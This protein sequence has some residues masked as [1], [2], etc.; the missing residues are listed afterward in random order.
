[1]KLDGMRLLI[2]R[3]NKKI[4]LYTRHKNEVTFQFKQFTNLDIPEGTIIDGELVALNEMGVPDFELLME[5]Y[6]SKNSEGV[7]FVAFDVIRYQ[8]E[9]TTSLPLLER[10]RILN[11]II[12]ED[13]TLIAKTQFI[14]GHAKEYFQAIKDR[15][16]EGICLKRTDANR[17]SF[18]QVGK[19]SDTWLKLINYSYETVQI[20]G[21]RDGEFGA[22][23]S[24][25]DGRAAGVMEFAPKKDR[26]KIYDWA[27]KTGNTDKQNNIWFNEAMKCEVKYRNLT[28]KGLLRIPS[29]DKWV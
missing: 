13:N 29:F 9:D 27:R 20:T 26:I 7:Q 6:R 25:M 2:T 18:Y 14:E 5:K 10:K 11:E 4:R 28:S 8:G 22:Y 15:G 16:L 21:I 3:F 1:M 24:F 17:N 12:P 19:R 23:L